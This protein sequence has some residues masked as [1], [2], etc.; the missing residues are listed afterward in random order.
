MKAPQKIARLI[1]SVHNA[2]GWKP[3]E[4]RIAE[5]GTSISRPYLWSTKLRYLTSLTIKPSKPKWKMDN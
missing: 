4:L 5:P 2:R 3:K 1:A